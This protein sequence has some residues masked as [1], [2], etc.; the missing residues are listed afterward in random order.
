M[1]ALYHIPA[2]AMSA[3]DLA[4]E[5]AERRDEWIA[6]RADQLTATRM[7]APSAL[8]AALE[9]IMAGD[10]LALEIDLCGF[11]A[12]MEA[13]RDDTDVLAAIGVRLWR[14]LRPSFVHFVHEQAKADAADE[15]D[16]KDA[17]RAA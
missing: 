16:A 15:H 5:A 14:A 8:R 1:T 11:A 4:E 2:H 3:E 6:D 7:K 9:S 17:R 12:D 10:T 13:A